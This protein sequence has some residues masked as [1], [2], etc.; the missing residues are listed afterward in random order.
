MTQAYENFIDKLPLTQNIIRL[1]HVS[2]L[3]IIFF[4]I[5]FHLDPPIIE[6]YAMTTPSFIIII[7]KYIRY[8]SLVITKT[9]E[10]NYERSRFESQLLHFV[11]YLY[12]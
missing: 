1:S 10:Y 7:F 6:I 9:M 4:M 3:Q 12:F 11:P 5:N 2:L 8:I